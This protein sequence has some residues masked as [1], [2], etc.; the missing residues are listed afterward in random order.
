MLP[1]EPVFEKLALTV[2]FNILEQT[3]FG[4]SYARTLTIW[5]EQFFETIET[6]REQGFDERFEKMWD[7]YLSYCEAGFKLG[8]IDVSQIVLGEKSQTL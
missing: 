6:V 1:S 8:T 2:G 4:E 5:R 7:Y 3:R